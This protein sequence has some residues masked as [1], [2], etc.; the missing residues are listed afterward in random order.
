MLY[1][2]T[3]LLVGF[4]KQRLK[5][6]LKDNNTLKIEDIQPGLIPET[7]IIDFSDTIKFLKNCKNKN[8]LIIDND[9]F[10]L[11]EKFNG[12]ISFSDLLQDEL[13]KKGAKD[14]QIIMD[15]MMK[16]NSN[17]F[18]SGDY[19]EEIKEEVK[20]LESDNKLIKAKK[21]I[22]QFV[23]IDVIKLELKFSN[24]ILQNISSAIF[25]IPLLMTLLIIAIAYTPMRN[26]IYLHAFHF[27][28]IYGQSQFFSSP[29]IETI[30]IW[31]IISLIFSIKNVMS[32]YKL[33][34]YNLEVI[35]PRIT[36]SWGFLFF[37][38][39]SSDIVKK[40]LFKS[41]CFYCLRIFFPFIIILACF[42][43]GYIPI[44]ESLLTLLFQLSLLISFVNISPLF[45]TEFN[46]ILRL[47]KPYGGDV[48]KPFAYLSQNFIKEIFNVKNKYK[49]QNFN[50]LTST[51]SIIWIYL[52]YSYLWASLK[53][54]LLSFLVNISQF[55]LAEKVMISVYI[56]SLAVP[57]VILLITTFIIGIQNFKSVARTP[58]YKLS[59][60]SQDI[61]SKK[62]PAK[63]SIY[64]FIHEIPLFSKLSESDTKSLCDI[65]RIIE[66]PS[67]KKIIVE[68]D[69]GTEFFTIVKGK[70]NV[71]K[72]LKSGAQRSVATLEIGDSFGEV[73]LIEDTYRTATVRAIT[74]T[75]L[76]KL[77][78]KGF[79]KFIK[80][81]GIDKEKITDMIGISKILMN[82]Q[83]FSFF[84][85]SQINS[86]ISKLQSANFNKDEMI[87]KQ[88]DLGDKFYIIQ[89]GEILI[90]H[91]EDGKITLEK[92]LFKGDYFGEIAL[93]KNISR[94]ASVISLSQSRTFYLTK[95]NFY[96]V[97]KDNLIV[98]IKLNDLANDR[99]NSLGK[100][101]MNNV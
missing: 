38:L 81:S 23:N 76:I 16:L 8:Y 73:A 98:G 20:I 12:K 86:L 55:T 77:D 28:T 69:K 82:I 9:E 51:Y 5:V 71:T 24:P 26:I 32:A 83:M 63:E 92:T 50:L 64:D 70:V 67:G 61:F 2:N 65:L 42:G 87:F 95:Q 48:V 72:R 94:T 58:I 15:L 52:F 96:D 62:V 21:K 6:N 97:I 60:I 40:G 41:I 101:F 30:S 37:T 10:K 7:E 78:K 74:K 31:I 59:K 43:W 14:F 53:L 54:N 27:K 17:G 35:N 49:G 85:P 25:S 45:K 90:Q 36:F 39:D 22:F 84:N 46:Q 80:K 57:S 19:A 47:I 93:I 44:D 75:F 89:D 11:I 66:V 3:K 34:Y 13:E 56:I 18:L 91:S 88:N 68:G 4:I 29:I 99:L 100:E 33:A 1:Y 79:D